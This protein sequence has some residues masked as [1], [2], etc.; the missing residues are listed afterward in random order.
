M[1][2]AL[3]LAEVIVALACL[4]VA[5]LGLVGAQLYVMR[6][7]AK[8]ERFHQASLLAGSQLARVEQKLRDDFSAVVDQPRTTLEPGYEWA[9]RR[10]PPADASLTAELTRVDVS[11]YYQDAQ[12][13]HEYQLWT[14]VT[15]P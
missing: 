14:Y 4:A 2:R 1:R 3:S 10:S 11:I 5:L 7:G 9:C 8:Q 12:G 13:P 6:A 15:K